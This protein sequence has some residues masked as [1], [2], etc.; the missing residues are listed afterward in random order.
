MKQ[1]LESALEELPV[2]DSVH[3][4]MEQGIRRTR[5][6]HRL[7]QL[8]LAAGL[9]IG[10]MQVD[11]INRGWIHRPGKRPLRWFRGW[12]IKEC[13]IPRPGRR[14]PKQRRNSCAD[15]S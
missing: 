12:F 1:Q 11:R 10:W 4:R 3:A 2:P 5:R 14:F 9:L 8:I 13:C 6:K 7:P 15:G